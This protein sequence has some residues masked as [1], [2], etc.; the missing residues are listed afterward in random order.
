MGERIV[1][2]PVTRIEGHA[3]I[4]VQLDDKTKTATLVGEDLHSP[5]LAAAF[6][7]NL[8]RLPNGDE[9]LGWG[10]QPYF[11]EFNSQGDM[12]FD[13]RFVDANSSYRAYRFPWTGTPADLPA[14]AASVAGSTT[15][16][17]VSWNGAT[18][19]AS[20]RVLA[21]VSTDSLEVVTTAAKQGFETQIPIAPQ[22]Y[23]AVQALNSAG[24]ALATSNVVHV[25]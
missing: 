9:F 7:G 1:I 23:I 3:K 5:A 13:G 6:E 15:N 25:G 17:Y 22:P 8:Q 24:R 11:T 12:V 4:T 20:W 16:V 10:Q 18:E 21:G 14:V 19:V 2:E